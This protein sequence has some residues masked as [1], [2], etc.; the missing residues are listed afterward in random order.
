MRMKTAAALAWAFVFAVSSA[1]AAP[2]TVAWEDLSDR[3]TG[4]E[5]EA[6]FASHEGE[7]LHA[8]SAHFIYHFADAKQAETVLVHAEE[9]YRWIRDLLGV[10]EDDWTE[11]VRIVVF[12]DEAEW[13][14]FIARVGRGRHTGAFTTGRELF[15]YRHPYWLA[16]QRLLA[17]ELAHVIAF[18]FLPGPIPLFLNEGLAEYVATKAAARQAGGDEYAV[19]TL[20]LIPEEE[21][22]P[23][24]ELTAMRAYPKDER[25]LTT[26]YRESELFVRYLVLERKGSFRAFLNDVASGTV[27]HR[28]SERHY[29]AGAP[30]MARE[31][32]EYALTG[33]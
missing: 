14:A 23:L 6:A 29:R 25:R 17:H 20:K 27:W 13:K 19:R 31:F 1:W 22:I 15:L 12:E 2:R 26:F 10:S 11:K 21:F 5:T 28:A 18:R 24:F 3:K 33:K 30:E 32:R 16:P 7:W 4:P 9:T 8:E